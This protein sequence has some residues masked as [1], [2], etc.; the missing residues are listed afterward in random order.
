[1]PGGM[2]EMLGI[3]DD[4]KKVLPAA[5]CDDRQHFGTAGAALRMQRAAA[6]RDDGFTPGNPARRRSPAP[7]VE[8]RLEHLWDH[9]AEA[10]IFFLDFTRFHAVFSL[11]LAGVHGYAQ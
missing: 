10:A 7:R 3:Y 8:V 6:G 4:R 11:P 9:S 1:M 2:L 5:S